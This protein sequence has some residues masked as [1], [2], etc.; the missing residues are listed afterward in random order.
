MTTRLALPGIVCHLINAGGLHTSVQA[1]CIVILNL[2]IK[3]CG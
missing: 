2:S 3:E 1:A